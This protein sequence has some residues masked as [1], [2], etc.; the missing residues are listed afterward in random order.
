M[1]PTLGL[2]IDGVWIDASD[3]ISE[4]V[5]NPSNGQIIGRL[6]HATSA[7]LDRALIAAKAAFNSWRAVSAYDRAKIIRKAAN[8]IRERRD[9]IAR[10]L[11]SEQ[12]KLLPEAQAEVDAAADIVEWSAEEGRRIYGRVIPARAEEITQLMVQDPVGPVAAFTPWNFPAST[13][14]RKVSG[15]LAAGCSIII[16]ASEETPATCIEIVKAFID[17]GLPGGV[18]NLVFGVPAAVSERLLSSPIIRKV[19][20]TGSIPVGKLLTKAAAEGMKRVTMELGGH[21]AALV[22]PDADVAST[23]RTLVAG[24]FRNAG[25]VCIA[26]SRLYIHESIQQQFVEEF[27]KCVRAIRVG[28]GFDSNATMGPLASS[29]RVE[30]MEAIIADAV[31]HGGQILCGGKRIV[32]PGYFFEPTVVLNPAADCRLMCEEP[33]GPIAPIISFQDFDAV[34][35]QANSLPYGLSAYVFSSQ[36]K[37]AMAAARKLEAGMIAVNSL[38]LALTETPFGGMKESGLGH[39][40]GTEGVEAYTSKKYISLL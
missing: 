25:Q 27:V 7:D 22:F 24:K 5:I 9:H 21:G 6:P 31:E 15:A 35:E 38:S 23:A 4:P 29:R 33:F 10:I 36:I 34:I 28:D 2:F 39:E 12:G 30:A 40:G 1:Y 18:L 37:T 13:P 16:K 26:P 3:R 14:A 17:A 32:G 19:S 20:F 8:L 11:T